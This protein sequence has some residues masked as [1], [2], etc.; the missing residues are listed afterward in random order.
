MSELDPIIH[1]PLRLRILSALTTL[2]HDERMDFVW[3][4]DLLGATDGNLGAHLQK[5]EEAGYL[6]VE[7]TFVNRKPKTLISASD[8]GRAAFRAHVNALREIIDAAPKEDEG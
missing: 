4:R 7:K 1:Q 6:N 5:L 8:K 3:L 2:R